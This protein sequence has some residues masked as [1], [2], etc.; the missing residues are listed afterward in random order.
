MAIPLKVLI[1]KVLSMNALFKHILPCG[2][3]LLA[4]CT[5]YPISEANSHSVIAGEPN[6][7]IQYIQGDN[8]D[9]GRQ[10]NVGETVTLPLA[11]GDRT[12]VVQQRYFSATGFTCFTLSNLSSSAQLTDS[13]RFN[14]CEYPK[15]WGVVRAFRN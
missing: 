11:E 10:V 3:L 14:L 15:G 13:P 2:F 8:N 1:G 5:S 6:H 4:G 9:F 12:V 7:A